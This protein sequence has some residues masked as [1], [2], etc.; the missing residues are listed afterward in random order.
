MFAG[1]ALGLQAINS[2]ILQL[3]SSSLI[4]L[5]AFLKEIA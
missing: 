1:E 4:A 3:G 2:D 5:E